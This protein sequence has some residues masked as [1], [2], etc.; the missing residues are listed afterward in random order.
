MPTTSSQVPSTPT[1]RALV[2]AAPAPGSKRERIILTGEPPNPPRAAWLRLP[3]ALPA[4]GS[5]LPRGDT[6]LMT[7]GGGRRVACHIV[8]GPVAAP[9]EAA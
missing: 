5:P 7:L 9:R 8:A 3:S 1:T 4:G 6:G 2:S